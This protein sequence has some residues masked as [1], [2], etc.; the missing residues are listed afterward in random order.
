MLWPNFN[1]CPEGHQLV[2]LIALTLLNLQP[3]STLQRQ[4]GMEEE[5]EELEGEEDEDEEEEDDE[6][7]VYESEVEEGQNSSRQSYAA[8]YAQM[9]RW[10]K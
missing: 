3:R 10:P 7:E 4:R 2:S 6:E 5:E 8:Q 9:R 1:Y